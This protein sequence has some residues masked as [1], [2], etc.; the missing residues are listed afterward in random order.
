MSKFLFNN[1]IKR[2]KRMPLKGKTA[3]VLAHPDDETIVGLGYMARLGTLAHFKAIDRLLPQFANRPLQKVRSLFEGFEVPVVYY[4][5]LGEKGNPN[6]VSTPEG[7]AKVRAQELDHSSR[8]LR[9]RYSLDDLGDGQLSEPKIYNRLVEHVGEFLEKEKPD[10]VITFADSGLT[11]HPDHIAI[12]KATKEA[13]KSYNAIH[14]SNPIELYFRVISR[15]DQGITGPFIHYDDHLPI[16]H[17]SSDRGFQR[18]KRRAIEAHTTQIPEMGTI[19]PAYARYA[20]KPMI[21]PKY[22]GNKH[23]LWKKETFHRVKS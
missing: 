13:V 3:F 15:D 9:S 4:A 7:L 2:H 19:Y 22:R 10:R 1:R 21:P 16:T 5:S 17:V 14:K 23:L 18:K 12:S 11:G 8:I 6:G 20:K